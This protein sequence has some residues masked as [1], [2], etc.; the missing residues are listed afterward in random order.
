MAKYNLNRKQY[1]CYNNYKFIY[2][3]LYSILEK[4][5]FKNNHKNIN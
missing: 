1:L 2:R 5:I 3:F 4:I